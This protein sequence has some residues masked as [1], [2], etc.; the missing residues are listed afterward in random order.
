MDACL[1][2]GSHQL[3]CLNELQGHVVLVEEV[4][5][6]H[7]GSLLGGGRDPHK[8]CVHSSIACALGGAALLAL[9]L[10]LH[11]QL[12]LDAARCGEVAVKHPV[13]VAG[14]EG[15]AAVTTLQHH[16]HRH[17]NACEHG[18]EV[19]PLGVAACCLQCLEL[20]KELCHRQ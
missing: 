6:V 5:Q 4:A 8:I 16:L 10:A 1:L 17:A 3:W 7:L 9:A 19:L 14:T 15:G 13:G 20:C 18:R 12:D 2:E 11:W